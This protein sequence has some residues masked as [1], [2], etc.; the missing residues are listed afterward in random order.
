MKTKWNHSLMNSRNMESDLN[1]Y[2]EKLLRELNDH[3]D[4]DDD[5]AVHA[6]PGHHDRDS[7]THRVKTRE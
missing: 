4:R 3:E 5:E 1:A 7:R 6:L 2:V